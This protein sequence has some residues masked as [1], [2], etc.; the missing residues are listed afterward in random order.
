MSTVCPTSSSASTHTR[1]LS[2]PLRLSLPPPPPV[3]PPVPAAPALSIV[4]TRFTTCRRGCSLPAASVPFC[5][6][7]RPRSFGPAH[8]L[9]SSLKYSFAHASRAVDFGLRSDGGMD[10]FGWHRRWRHSH[11]DRA[12]SSRRCSEDRSFRAVGLTLRPRRLASQPRSMHLSL[13]GRSRARCAQPASSF[14]R[15]SGVLLGSLVLRCPPLTV[16]AFSCLSVCAVQ[17]DRCRISR[18]LRLLLLLRP[19]LQLPF[20]PL[21]FLLCRL[22]RIRPQLLTPLPMCGLAPRALR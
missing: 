15:A 20:R 10:E 5:T 21:Q 12:N 22:Q 8:S 14:L 19:L 13:D 2:A 6:L 9:N 1:T 7:T 16:F 4:C 17:C 18:V 3:C 11:G